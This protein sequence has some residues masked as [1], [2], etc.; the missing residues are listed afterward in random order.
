LE[1]L[2]VAAALAE[3]SSGK[4]IKCNHRFRQLVVLLLR[5]PSEV[6]PSGGSGSDATNTTTPTPTTTTTES[7]TTDFYFN[8]SIWQ[9][10]RVRVDADADADVD[11]AIEKGD[12]R[13]TKQ[14]YQGENVPNKWVRIHVATIERCSEGS[15]EEETTPP[16]TTTT[17]T[18]KQ[19]LIQVEDVDEPMRAKEQRIAILETSYDGFWDYHIPK[20]YEYMSPRFWEMFGYDAAEKQHK[21][22]EWM[23]IIHQEDLKA[24]MDDLG[25]HF[26]SKG[27]LPYIRETRFKHKD[28]SWV[29]VLC[30]GKVIEWGEDGS[31]LRMIGT[32]TDITESKIKAMREQKLYATIEEEHKRAM[33]ATE[34]LRKF[35][36]HVNAPVFG[37]DTSGVINIWND[38]MEKITKIPEATII[39]KPLATSTVKNAQQMIQNALG[40]NEI[41][42]ALL[43]VGSEGVV[44]N[45]KLLVNTTTRRNMDG[46]VLGCFCFGLDV[47]ELELAQ[48]KLVQERERFSA[49]KQLNEVVSH[50]VRNPLAAAMSA[51]Q[52]IKDELKATDGAVITEESK[53]SLV[54]DADLVASSLDYIQELLTNMLD[55]NQFKENGITLV[56]RVVQLKLDI[57]QPVHNMYSHRMDNLQFSCEAPEE[58]RIRVDVLRFKQIIVNLTSNAVKFTKEGFVRVKVGRLDLFDPDL[59]CI[60]IEDSGPGVPDEKRKLLFERYVQ[61]SKQVQG[62]GIGLCL[63]RHLVEAMGGIIEIDNSYNS[64]VKGSPGTR[65]VV[66]IPAPKIEDNKLQKDASMQPEA[67]LEASIDKTQLT[68]LKNGAATPESNTKNFQAPTNQDSIPSNLNV[69]IVDDDRIIRKL[70]TRRLQKID[71]TMN[72][73]TAESGEKAIEMITGPNSKDYGLVLMDHF[74]PL[75]GGELTG[76]ETIG[77]IRPH[78]KGI[79]AGSS[80][81]DMSKEHVAAGADLFWLK[82][83]PKDHTVLE[84]LRE[85]FHLKGSAGG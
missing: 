32:H 19:L 8:Q 49:E 74:M 57:V 5:P 70:L 17:T 58:Q 69:L 40:E 23:G 43:D 68:K 46:T 79:I 62:S 7:P 51:T 81:N 12:T 44:Q 80:G 63:T 26:A 16:P 52:F 2:C 73:E 18:T 35:V 66:K 77:I 27:T 42:N 85:A 37:T 4:L 71:K 60:F 9:L 36:Q 20:D 15:K 84:D 28:G 3:P 47:T 78:V 83:V 56:P 29:W 24:S 45:L 59:L 22:S 13:I 50:E 33:A 65:F 53:D 82:P 64:G 48:D 21:P 25:K 34:E 30:R 75:C 72:V 6:Q 31:P 11:P 10:L 55:L 61:L 41:T 38:R 67:S 1:S 76:E 54:S 14:I 39:G